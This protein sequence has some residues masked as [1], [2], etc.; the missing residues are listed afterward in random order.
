MEELC[1][2]EE[3]REIFKNNEK[4][5]SQARSMR[6]CQGYVLSV[7]YYLGLDHPSFWAATEFQAGPKLDFYPQACEE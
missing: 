6:G 4:T 2:K 1:S 3:A 7:P 5:V